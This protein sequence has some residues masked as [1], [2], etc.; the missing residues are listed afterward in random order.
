MAETASVPGGARHAL[1]QLSAHEHAVARAALAKL[2]VT[3]EHFSH[4]ALGSDSI[5]VGE[6][7]V[8]MLGSGTDTE[9]GGL[10]DSAAHGTDKLLAGS[11]HTAI[12]HSLAAAP[13]TAAPMGEIKPAG[14]T[15]ASFAGAQHTEV[16]AGASHTIN[17]A[18]KTTVKLIGIKTTHTGKI[19]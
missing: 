16:K 7:P 8:T 6:G 19:H 1:S 17:M 5:T 11:A 9:V 2:G 12:Q 15:A 14:H 10:H 18:D 4:S 13:H 3:T